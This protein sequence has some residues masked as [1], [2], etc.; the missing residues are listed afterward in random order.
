MFSPT[1]VVVG[2]PVEVLDQGSQRVAVRDDQHRF[3]AAQVRDDDVGEIRQEADHHVGQAFGQRA[4]ADV[5][6]SGVGVL[7]ELAAL[8][9]RWWRD[10]VAAPPRHE[11]LV[12]VAG[13]GLGLVQPLQRPVVPFVEPPAAPYRNPQPV[14]GRPA[15]GARW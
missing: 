10:V 15:P 9:D 13:L 14:G 2:H 8:L 3:A 6:V 7:A 4:A 5:G 12:A 11:L 1:I